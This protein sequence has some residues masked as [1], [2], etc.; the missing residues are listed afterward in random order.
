MNIV[1]NTITGN[2]ANFGSGICD[3]FPFSSSTVNVVNTIC[4]G[5]DGSANIH[6]ISAG[7]FE[8]QFSDIGDPGYPAPPGN[9]NIAPVFVNAAAGDYHLAPTGN[10]GIINGG[11]PVGTQMG[12]Y[13][14]LP[15]GAV[16][17]FLGDI[18]NNTSGYQDDYQGTPQYKV[19][20]YIRE[21]II[22]TY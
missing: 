17:G 5:N 22:G 1:N 20:P 7:H 8:Y 3:S 9:I 12:A 16:I 14:G 2:S 4:H 21:D 18:A 11:T 10:D 19:T 15:S 13:G 6:S